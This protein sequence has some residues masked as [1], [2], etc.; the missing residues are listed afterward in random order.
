MNIKRMKLF[1]MLLVVLI[2]L[3]VYGYSAAGLRSESRYETEEVAVNDSIDQRLDELL[4]AVDNED[5]DNLIMQV[6]E[7]NKKGMSYTK[8]LQALDPDFDPYNTSNDT[9]P[10]VVPTYTKSPVILKVEEMKAEGMSDDEIVDALKEK[11]MWWDP[12]TGN[13]MVGSIPTQEELAKLAPNNGAYRGDDVEKL[14]SRGVQANPVMETEEVNYRGF[15]NLVRPGSLSVETGEVYQHLV[16]TH[17]KHQFSA[18]KDNWT[19][20]GIV[21]NPGAGWNHRIFTFDDDELWEGSN[22]GWHGTAD[23]DEWVDFWIYIWD[24]YDPGLGYPYTIWINGEFARSGHVP[25]K[26]CFVNQANEVWTDSIWT[27]DSIAAFHKDPV[28]YPAD[29]GVISWNSAVPTR[30]WEAWPGM[31]SGACPIA[32][33][34]RIE[35]D[36]WQFV[37]YTVGDGHLEYPCEVYDFDLS[38]TIEKSEAVAAIADYLIDGQIDKASAVAVLNCYFFP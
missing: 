37:T 7:M 23:E 1:G 27:Q 19:E 33:T 29:G 9:I 11:G 31:P 20:A 6:Y 3:S 32:N 2:L 17:I 36:K 24:D 28:L 18:E 10:L 26:F 30:F 5:A 38:G 22:W 21:S 13:T 4:G 15:R 14:G 35:D 12:E 8:M 34:T 25:S 16:T